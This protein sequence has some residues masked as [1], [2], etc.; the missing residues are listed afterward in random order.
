MGGG[1]GTQPR[2]D[3]CLGASHTFLPPSEKERAA[4]SAG[5]R[6]ARAG[7]ATARGA[8]AKAFWIMER[9]VAAASILRPEAE[10]AA[11]RMHSERSIAEDAIAQRKCEEAWSVGA[12]TSPVLTPQ[13]SRPILHAA[14]YSCKKH[15][16][17][18]SHEGQQTSTRLITPVGSARIV[19]HRDERRGARSARRPR[20]PLEVPLG[21]Q[22]NMGIEFRYTVSTFD[23]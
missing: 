15:D 5:V 6:L 3:R 22:R 1:S 9:R 8:T 10:I 20:A 21:R 11:R 13:P 7:A 16:G 4:A 17:F 12:V 18:F 19:E 23:T 14:H 2:S